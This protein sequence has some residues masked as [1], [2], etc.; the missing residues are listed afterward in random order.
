[1]KRK[2]GRFLSD[3]LIPTRG[4]GDQ[5]IRCRLVARDFKGDDNVRDVLFAENP[6][7]EAKRLLMSR[8]ATRRRDGKFR[9]PRFMDGRKAHLNPACEEDVYIQFLEECCAPEGMCGKLNCWLYGFRPAVAAWEKMSSK[10]SEQVGFVR[11][12]GC[13]FFS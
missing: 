8:S 7:L 9:K 11:G 12:V 13:A 10:L 5:S 2:S 1:M 6:P 3:G 4:G